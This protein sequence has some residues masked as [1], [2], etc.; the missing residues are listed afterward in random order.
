MIKEDVKMSRKSKLLIPKAFCSKYTG[1]Y[2]YIRKDTS[3]GESEL[4]FRDQL[5]NSDRLCYSVSEDVCSLIFTLPT[6]EERNSEFSES[7]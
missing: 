7:V 6:L 4:Q 1:S 5:L 3:G 2:R